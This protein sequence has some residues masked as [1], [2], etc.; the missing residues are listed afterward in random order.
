M[1]PWLS[2]T[3]LLTCSLVG[4]PVWPVAARPL[5]VAV[6]LSADS[7]I[8]STVRQSLESRLRA[9][10]ATRVTT[11]VVAMR[12]ASRVRADLLVPVGAEATRAALASQ[13]TPVLSVLVAESA[14]AELREAAA[15]TGNRAVSA[16]YLDQPVERQLALGRVLLPDARRVG[17]LVGGDE[18]RLEQ[19]LRRSAERVGLE[20]ELEPVEEPAKPAPEIKRLLRRVDWVAAVYDPVAL[21]PAT[22]KWLLYMAYQEGIPVLGFSQSYA[23]AGALAAVYSTPAQI[24]RQAAER[25]LAWDKGNRGDLGGP[26]YPEYFG[27]QTNAS[28]AH[29]LGIRLPDQAG[30]VE[31]IGRLLEG[32][33]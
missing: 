28:V 7:G 18:P 27:V 26:A 17:V 22:A 21:N 12:E 15:E 29:A 31:R 14:F 16:I 25:I 24:G 9:E 20:V 23:Q 8:Y 2:S 1:P 6:I 33:R 10:P 30:L 4:G 5:D 13:G 32:S 11:R 19:N 3:L